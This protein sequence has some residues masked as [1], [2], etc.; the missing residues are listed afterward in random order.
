MPKGSW[1]AKRERQYEHIL[2]SCMAKR[3]KKSKKTCQRIAAATVNKARSGAGEL[4]SAPDCG[5]GG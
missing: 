1:T 5:C 4:K 3:G 2:E